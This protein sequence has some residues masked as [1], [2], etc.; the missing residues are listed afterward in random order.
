MMTP[1]ILARG[2]LAPSAVAEPS[3]SS[4][5]AALAEWIERRA[6]HDQLAAAPP[7][8]RARAGLFVQHAPGLVAFG[9]PGIPSLLLNRVFVDADAHAATF[10]ALP[11]TLNALSVRGM[12]SLLVHVHEP[13]PQHA[14][15]ESA[16]AALL[17]AGLVPYR[18]AWLKL[19]RD[20]GPQRE[21]GA[22][23]PLELC[24]T[25]E[26]DA[27][28][29]LV[30][31]GLSLSPESAALIAPLVQRPRWHVFGA[32]DRGV[33]VAAGALFVQGELGQLGFA[34]TAPGYRGL[35]LQRALIARRLRVAHALGCRLVCSETGVALPGQP[36][37]SEH[38]LRALGLR[39]V[40]VRANWTRPGASWG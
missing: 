17:R 18:R 29:E 13:P 12:R 6:L 34:A 25:D 4:S 7:A 35:G 3:P 40:A 16:T 19:A 9:A 24:R 5:T 20:A 8:L 26:A 23:L 36:N 33:L 28:A 32:R 11:D 10:D 22:P 14:A 31:T 27:F 37:P 2:E 38:N 15:G 30:T 1:R 39:P 21:L